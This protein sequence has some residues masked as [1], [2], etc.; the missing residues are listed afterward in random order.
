MD[1]MTR[2]QLKQDKLRTAFEHYEAFIKEHFKKIVAAIAIVLVVLGSAA[3]FKLYNDRQQSAAN[4]QLAGALKTFR[5]YVGA[6]SAEAVGP[7]SQ[8]FSTPQE[9]YKKALGQF[10]EVA[11]KYPHQKAG[12]I[13]LY[14]AGVCQ[15]ALGDHAAA[16]KT[17]Q[18]ASSASDRDVAALAKMALAGELVNQNKLPDAIRVYQQLADHPTTTVPRATALLALADAERTTRP[19]EAREIYQRL[20]KEIGSNKTLASLLKDQIASLPK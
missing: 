16:T 17:L 20:Q 19:A 2:H 4:A 14:H 11:S 6:A 9:K 12:E 13:A 1:R 10:V 7:D 8:T 15:S 5:A 3:A 18:Q